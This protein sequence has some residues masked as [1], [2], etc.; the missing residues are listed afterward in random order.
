MATDYSAGLEG[1]VAG[2]SSISEVDAEHN[3]L[4]YR[5]YSAKDLVEQCSFEE[6]AYLILY[7]ELPTQQEYRAFTSRVRMQRTVPDSVTNLYRTFDKNA[8]PMDM[9][10]AAVAVLAAKIPNASEISSEASLAAAESLLAKIPTLVVNGYRIMHGDEPR[11][12]SVELDHNANFFEML[13]GIVPNPLFIQTLNATQI[14]Y[15]EHGFNAS[16]FSSRVTVSTL[17]DVYC[18]V[19]SAIGTLK[20]PLHGGANEHAMAMLLEIGSADKAET[21]VDDALAS[22]RKIMGFG[23]REYKKGDSRAVIVKEYVERLSS[24]LGNKQWLDISNMVEAKMLA[25]KNLY[26]NLYTPIF[27][28]SRVVGWSANII[29]QLANNRI[30][31]PQSEYNGPHG[32]KVVAIESRK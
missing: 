20:G 19:V 15:M 30:F 22:K 12:P 3:T 13:T 24:A 26:P 32:K 6:V 31:R 27:V 29:E 18:G 9:L 1:V 7:G 4:I 11:P 25:S 16:T 14:L 23:H 17:A 8:H 2:I 28:M 5:G 21:W 10:K